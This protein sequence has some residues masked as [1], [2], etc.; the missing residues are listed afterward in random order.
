MI[1]VRF[2]SSKIDTDLINRI[3]RAIGQKPHRFLRRGIFFSHRWVFLVLKFTKVLLGRLS[4]TIIGRNVWLAKDR[5]LLYQ[6]KPAVSFEISNYCR[7]PLATFE[8]LGCISFWCIVTNP[9]L[10]KYMQSLCF[11]QIPFWL[12]F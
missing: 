6:G 8:T 5:V 4:V 1:I 10:K 2:G 12:Y 11:V 9:K 3:E 7:F